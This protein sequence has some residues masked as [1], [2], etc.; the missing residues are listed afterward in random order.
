MEALLCLINKGRF[1]VSTDA[2][3][4]DKGT[5]KHLIIV[6]AYTSIQTCFWIRK[7][8]ASLIGLELYPNYVHT[9]SISPGKALVT[10]P[11]LSTVQ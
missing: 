1:E 2:Q 3:I 6:F 9:S 10:S 5:F 4:T 8:T 11:R 7:R